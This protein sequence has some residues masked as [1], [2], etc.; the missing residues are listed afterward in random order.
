MKKPT[1]LKIAARFGNC[2]DDGRHH[3][4]TGDQLVKSVLAE[5]PLRNFLAQRAAG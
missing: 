2:H 1:K 3:G 5:T 4:A